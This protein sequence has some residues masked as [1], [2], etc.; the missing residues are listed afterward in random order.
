[1][2]HHLVPGT[3]HSLIVLNLALNLTPPSV[4]I[5][6]LTEGRPSM[7]L[8]CIHLSDNTVQLVTGICQQ[9]IE[10]IKNSETNMQAR[11]AYLIILKV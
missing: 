8:A 11:D 6:V 3:D 5:L 7:S 1:M 9:G 2:H 4:C 10:A